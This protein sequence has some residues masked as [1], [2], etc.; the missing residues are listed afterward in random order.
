MT[1]LPS[2]VPFEFM[3]EGQLKDRQARCLRHNL[4]HT[5]TN[6]HNNNPINRVSS[7]DRQVSVDL[8]VCD[9]NSILF[10]LDLLVLDKV[11]EHVIA[12]GLS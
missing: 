7:Q 10:P 2:V 12:Q 1:R 9:V 5:K 4:C 3:G 11:L 8:V 6:N